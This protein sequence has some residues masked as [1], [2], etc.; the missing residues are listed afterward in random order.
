MLFTFPYRIS[1][2]T[3]LISIFWYSPSFAQYKVGRQA[4]LIKFE[5]DAAPPTFVRFVTAY[6]FFSDAC[7]VTETLVPSLKTRQTY[8][9]HPTMQ[10]VMHLTEMDLVNPEEV[11]SVLPA[12]VQ[13]K[14]VVKD[15]ESEKFPINLTPLKLWTIDESNYNGDAS[16]PDEEWK[17]ETSFSSIF[18][19]DPHV[20]FVGGMHYIYVDTDDDGTVDLIQFY[21]EIQFQ[22]PVPELFDGTGYA[23]TDE[24]RFVVYKREAGSLA[25]FPHRFFVVG[26][27]R[28]G[29]ISF[30]ELF[31]P[32]SNG[33]GDISQDELGHSGYQVR[34]QVRHIGGDWEDD[35]ILGSGINNTNLSFTILCHGTG[36]CCGGLIE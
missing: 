34:R 27:T 4:I 3:I 29:I 5:G 20:L 17:L 13:G 32:D 28:K 11:V 7:P 9:D 12:I 23:V 1:L 31:D 8:S 19:D 33:D 36:S 21:N 10:N 14:D 25:A 30:K 24:F 22:T 16:F 2:A 15:E 18:T 26:T 6:E 35:F